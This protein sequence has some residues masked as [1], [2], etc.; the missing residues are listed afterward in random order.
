MPPPALPNPSAGSYL[1]TKVLT[2]SPEE[3]RLM[4]LEGCLKFARQGR[5][6]LAARDFEASYTGFSRCRAVLV[7]LMNSMRPEHDPELCSRLAG[8]YT[9]LFNHLVAGAHEKDIAKI[10][11]VIGV[12][13]YERQT[14][15]MLI[16]TITAGRA[17]AKSE[18]PIDQTPS[19]TSFPPAP[20]LCVEG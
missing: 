10:D 14:W 3:L 17:G 20:L 19:D 16:E 4:L 9:F 11:K 8:L 13:D 6:G 7:E 18:P 15:R 5:D 12:L 2:A 1:R